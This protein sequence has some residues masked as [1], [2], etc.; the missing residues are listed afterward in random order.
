MRE[1]AAMKNTWKQLAEE[2][3]FSI[4]VQQLNHIE[5]KS[6]AKDLESIQRPESESSRYLC[7]LDERTNDFLGVK[8]ARSLN[9]IPNNYKV[10][11]TAIEFL[12]ENGS[13]PFFLTMKMSRERNKFLT[14]Y[15][16]NRLEYYFKHQNLDAS[17]EH[18]N[19][20][21][22][23]K[24]REL[25]KGKDIHGFLDRE[26]STKRI[27]VSAVNCY[28]LDFYPGLE[29]GLAEEDTLMAHRFI[30]LE[31]YDI[32]EN[33][34][35]PVF[36]SFHSRLAEY[37]KRTFV[38]KHTVLNPEYFEALVFDISNMQT[39]RNKLLNDKKV[40]ESA[41]EL[42]KRAELFKYKKDE[43]SYYDLYV[44]FAEVK[45]IVPEGLSGLSYGK[46][47]K[48]LTKDMK[49]KAELIRLTNLALMSPQERREKERMAFDTYKEINDILS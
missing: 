8:K 19:K 42:K 12:K 24:Y 9:D 35:I 7:V 34:W 44:F 17:D 40:L 16:G 38:F 28:D 36:K 11:K 14:C 22:L 45:R 26:F 21:I 3:F 15:L 25:I 47:I 29:V 23:A 5:K 43:L 6:A 32:T 13:E 2:C 37:V 33:N 31:S 39:G 20:D 10:D 48:I 18:I 27:F 1:I 30:H 46:L 4:K 49:F 41:R